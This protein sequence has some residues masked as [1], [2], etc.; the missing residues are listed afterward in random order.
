VFVQGDAVKAAF[1]TA[2]HPYVVLLSTH[3]FFLEDT[4]VHNPLL[5]CGL[6]FAGANQRPKG[7]KGEHP[8]ILLGL[9]VCETELR[10]TD[11][12]VL[13]ACQTGLGDVT[14]GEGVGGLRQTFL[15]AGARTV[16][17]S[18]WE[19]PDGDTL[20]LM[21]NYFAHLAQG[22][23]KAEA[24]CQAQVDL[25]TANK[26]RYGSAHPFFWAAFTSTGQ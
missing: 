8:S 26:K 5:R 1:K 2:R 22:Q 14:R 9:E 18:L 15:L 4:K 7:G 12:V 20:K 6:V 21:T 13:S 10:G 16:V 11:L 24:L 25:L 23:P 3:G 19:V 17:A